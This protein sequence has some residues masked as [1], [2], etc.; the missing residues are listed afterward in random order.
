MQQNNY[1]KLPKKI[2]NNN[3]LA[4]AVIFFFLAVFISSRYIPDPLP[5]EIK[6][7]LQNEGYEVDDVEFTCITKNK[8]F[9]YG[10]YRSSRPILYENVPITKWKVYSTNFYVGTKYVVVPA[11]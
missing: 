11:E 9:G 5:S 8:V 10:V 2:N 1:K 6:A 4:A 7:Y 3:L